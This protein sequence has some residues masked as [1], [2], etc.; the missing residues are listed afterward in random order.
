MRLLFLLTQDLESPS[1][2]GRYWPLARELTRRGHNTTIV[3]LHPNFESLS[4]RHFVQQG[5]SIRYVG[6]MHVRKRGSQ[7]SYYKGYQLLFTTLR[8]IIALTL[9]ALLTPADIIYVCKPHPMN[10]IAGF[11]VRYLR[12]K[13]LFVDCDDYE[14]ASNRFSNRCQKEIITWFEKWAPKLANKVTTNTFFMMDKLISWGVPQNKIFYLP[15]GVDLT[16]FVTPP[17]KKIEELR[18]KLGLRDK[19][20]VA[21]IG[22]LSLI[23]HAVD[24][25]LQ[26]FAI[27]HSEI[28]NSVL[29]IVGSGEDMDQL[30]QLAQILNL[31][32]SVI[33]FGKVPPEEVVNYYYLA[34]VTVDPVRDEEAARGRAPL[35]LFE[36]WAC[37]VPVVT[38]DVGDR[39]IL[40]GEPPSIFLVKPSSHTDLSHAIKEVLTNGNLAEELRQIGANRTKEYTWDRL[41]NQVEFL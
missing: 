18:D 21:Y 36:S 10:S 40:A 1:G 23:S 20:V 29:L 31:G 41:I 16:R 38:A 9:A 6:P 37:G 8:S 13:L 2:L 12:N 26:A 39:K 30:K 15:N 11:L 17:K 4:T 35:K 33:F 19:K 27:V 7:K 34:D 24:L 32:K 5:V 28:P 25:L 3:A 14:A 22:S